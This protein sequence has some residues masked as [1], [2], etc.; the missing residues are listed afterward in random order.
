MT[1]VVIDTRLSFGW[2][3]PVGGGILWKKSGGT[4]E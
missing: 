3:W 2:S 4:T 1:E